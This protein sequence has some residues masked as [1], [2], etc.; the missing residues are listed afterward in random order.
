VLGALKLVADSCNL[1]T[2]LLNTTALTYIDQ[3]YSI[4][5]DM[6]NIFGD[7]SDVEKI[8][9][10]GAAL[11]QALFQYSVG[12]QFPAVQN[13]AQD[14]GAA[15]VDLFT[16]HPLSLASDVLSLGGDTIQLILSNPYLQAA[17]AVLN[18]Y[19]TQVEKDLGLNKVADAFESLG[20]WLSEAASLPPGTTVQPLGLNS[21]SFYD[22]LQADFSWL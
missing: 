13:V 21:A 12:F 15:F 22:A 18:T 14:V 1:V 8:A 2:N 17:A 11:G 3:V 16:G 4:G 9:S 5:A 6:V 20:D 10:D 7:G 19:A